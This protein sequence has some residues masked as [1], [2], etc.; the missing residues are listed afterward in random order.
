VSD[1]TAPV[2]VL[3]TERAGA[4]ADGTVIITPAGR[5]DLII[6][7][8]TPVV[9]V[10]VRGLRTDVQA[11]VGFL[12]LGLGGGLDNIGGV[13]SS[14]FIVQLKIAASLALAPAVIAV[15]QNSAELLAKLD[16]RMPKA[17]A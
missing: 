17:R 16:E 9:Q 1:T 10:I 4:P 6:K 8:M 11:L 5:A 13:Q 7:T 14:V 12:L 3:T 2:P 15:L